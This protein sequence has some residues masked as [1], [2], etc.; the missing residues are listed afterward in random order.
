MHT[1]EGGERAVDPSY[2]HGDI[3]GQ[4]VAAAGTSI[5]LVSRSRNLEIP[6]AGYEV[7]REGV[8][9][10]EIIDDRCDRVFHERP[11]LQDRLLFGLRQHLKGLIKI[12]VGL[13]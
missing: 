1:E 8:L 5:T 10:P 3:A 2:L 9:R 7:K 6:E 4:K 11:N 13:R 12:A